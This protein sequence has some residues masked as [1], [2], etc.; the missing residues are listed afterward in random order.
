[1]HYS[2]H[3]SRAFRNRI[4]KSIGVLVA[5]ALIATLGLP[6]AAQAQ[7]IGAEG[8]TFADASGFTVTWTTRLDTSGGADSVDNWIVTFTRPN[9]M[10]VVLDESDETA[11]GAQDA[12]TVMLDEDD[13][14]TWWI[15]VAACFMAFDADNACPSASLETGTAVGYTHGAPSAPE[16]LTAS[17]VP[18]GVALTW[19]AIM[20]DRGISGYEYSQDGFETEG[21]M[22]S[23]A[24][25]N[26]VE[27]DPG[28]HTF[29]VRAIGRSDNDLN[30][31]DDPRDPSP[32]DAAS[33]E[34]TVP[35]P[36][37]TLPEIAALFLAM[38]L[39][40]SGAYLLRRRQ[41][42]GLTPA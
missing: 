7:A 13:L 23:D 22:A 16:N 6:S 4:A 24:G 27:V 1:M 25:A 31:A 17:L 29:S 14:G 26:V 2:V 30:T 35:M 37:P 36:T 12:N 20:G 15:Q 40:G 3:P 32:G 10:K 42:G 11:L 9:G 18:G 5:T 34:I 39:L 28:E 19:T 41:S 33:V 8:V 21:K 38:L